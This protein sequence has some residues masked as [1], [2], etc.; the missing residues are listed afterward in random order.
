MKTKAEV[1]IEETTALGLS[2]AESA[3]F[4]DLLCVFLTKRWN[5]CLICSLSLATPELPI[6]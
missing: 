6:G 1:L 5:T 2:S 4:N 3:S